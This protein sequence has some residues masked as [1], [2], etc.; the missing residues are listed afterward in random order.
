MV[1]IRVLRGHSLFAHSLEG[2]DEEWYFSVHP[3]WRETWEPIVL[4]FVEKYVPVHTEAMVTWEWDT[5][6]SLGETPYINQDPPL[7]SKMKG[8]AEDSEEEDTAEWKALIQI[9]LEMQDVITTMFDIRM[10]QNRLIR[11]FDDTRLQVAVKNIIQNKGVGDP[12]EH[13]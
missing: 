6:S 7:D 5:A 13:L 8:V 9:D 2:G 4:S 12:G 10:K 11:N 1:G 3:C